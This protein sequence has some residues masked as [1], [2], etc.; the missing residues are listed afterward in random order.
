M[1][2]YDTESTSSKVQYEEVT[3]FLQE[4]V[5]SIRK[6]ACEVYKSVKGQCTTLKNNISANVSKGL[7]QTENGLR[8]VGITD[9]TLALQVGGV[10]A[11]MFLG[12]FMARKRT[13]FARVL[14]PTVAAGVVGGAAYLSSQENREASRKHLEELAASW[15]KRTPTFK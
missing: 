7:E 10:G 3:V 13:V 8:K 5:S 4:E 15:K 2:I 9:T 12:Y 6:A 14:Y 11:A 1:S